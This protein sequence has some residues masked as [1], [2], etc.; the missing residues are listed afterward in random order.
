[1]TATNTELLA[2]LG[3]PA[4]E[5]VWLEF[6]R[7][8]RPIVLGF[9]RRIGLTEHDA[10]DLAQ[11]TLALFVR[12]YRAGKYQ[13]DRGRL[14]SWLIGMA[15]IR[16]AEMRR[17][18]FRRREARGE[19]AFAEMPDEGTLEHIWEEEMRR[20]IL[21][22]AMAELRQ[23]RTLKQVTLDAFERLVVH[24]EAPDKVAERYGLS[25]NGVYKAKHRCMA[26]L[27]TLLTKLQR[28]YEID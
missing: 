21:R 18:H 24:H 4:D 11:E 2:R 27:R 7:R 25:L 26:R 6:D 9:A 22:T 23:S 17:R 12:E 20:E 19:S 16:A 5:E 28:A 15:R 8:Y 3:D 10:S 1:M 14:R 13:R